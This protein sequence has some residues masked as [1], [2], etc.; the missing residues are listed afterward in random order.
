MRSIVAAACIAIF[1]TAADISEKLDELAAKQGIPDRGAFVIPIDDPTP[2]N[3]DLYWGDT[4]NDNPCGCD[5][6][7]DCRWSWL[8][9]DPD[10]WQGDS[11]DCRCF[12]D[13]IPDPDDYI[14]G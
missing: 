8:R 10:S 11:A 5:N 7:D 3:S 2:A 14:Y 4:C 1:T 9:D 6:Y 12:D 13:P